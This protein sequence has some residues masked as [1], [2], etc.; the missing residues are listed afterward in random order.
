MLSD[1]FLQISN[2][3]ASLMR[4]HHIDYGRINNWT[5]VHLPESRIA[6]SSEPRGRVVESR[7]VSCQGRDYGHWQLT[8]SN[9]L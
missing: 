8:I 4:L 7:E 1:M 6:I 9:G 3:S 5:L 2:L